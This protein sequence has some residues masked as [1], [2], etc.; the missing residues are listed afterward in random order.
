MIKRELYLK[1]LRGY[2]DKKLIKV[3]TGIRRCGKSTI[4][5]QF[6]T[7]LRSHGVNEK[8]IQ[9]INFEDMNNDYLRD[10]KT[11]HNHLLSLL[12]DEM[13]YI[14]LDEIQQVPGFERVLDSL[15]IRS[16]VDLYVTGSN[17]SMLSGELATLLSGRYVEIFMLPL[18]LK[19]YSQGVSTQRDL[20]ILYNEYITQSSFPYVLD[21]KED[22]NLVQGYLEGIY[23]TVVLKDVIS[24]NKIAD[25]LMLESVIKFL[26]DSIGSPISLK[27]ISDTLTSNGRKI[28][29]NTVESYVKGLIDSFLIYPVNR[30]DLK[31]KMH[32]KTH[33]KFYVVDVGFRQLLL[34]NKRGDLGHLLENVVYLELLRRGYKI[35][36][37]KIQD[38]EIDF[39]VDTGEEINYI[40]VAATVRSPDIYEREI[41][42]LK[43]IKDSYPKYILTLDNDVK[44]NDN[45]IWIMNALEYIMGG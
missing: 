6:A 41:R 42:V 25:A 20:Q 26:F 44:T 13:N 43:A 11:L 23:N 37:G 9:F 31:G 36:I 28:S 30:Y 32:L 12:N 40:E 27:K 14:F 17:A 39:V 19:E 7:E 3:I 4:L 10:A 15:Y 29:S 22:K 34:G 33:G 5:E 1:K 21:L 45:G 18:S 2:K 24:R 16:N 38:M 35:S 8:R